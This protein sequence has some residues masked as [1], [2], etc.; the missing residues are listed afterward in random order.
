MA[1][2]DADLADLATG[3]AVIRVVPGL[4]REIEGN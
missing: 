1:D 3:Q 4:G 2:G